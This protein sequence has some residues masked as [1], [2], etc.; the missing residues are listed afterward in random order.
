MS[1][2]LIAAIAV[3]GILLGK[4]FFKKWFNPLTLYCVIMG[5]LVFLYQLK[6]LP[7]PDIIP[8]AW[9]MLAASFI[10]FVLG[11]ITLTTAKNLYSD[12]QLTQTEKFISLKIFDDGGK[13]IKYSILFFSFIGLFVALHR[14][15]I[16]IG[17]FG[18]IQDVIINAAVVYR[19]NVHGEIKEFI[20][21]LPIFIYVGVFLSGIYTAYKGKSSFLSFL[22]ILTIIL[23]ELTY[24]GRGEI[25]FS[26]M[27][28]IFT[29]VLFR[30]LLTSDSTSRFKISKINAIVATIILLAILISASSFIRISR[31]AK[32]NYVGTDKG[33]RQLKDNFLFSPS[34]YLYLSSDVGVFSKY[35][36]LE[37]EKA[38]FGQNT[39]HPLYELLSRIGAVKKPDFFQKGYFIPMWTNTGTFIREVHADF[40]ITG[41]LL[42]PYL[43]GFTI[44]W[45][46]FRFY[47]NKSIYILVLLVYLFLVIGFSFIMMITRLNIWL[48]SLV[49]IM[50]YLPILHKLAG[51]ESSIVSFK[52]Y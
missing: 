17:K 49:F 1:L 21:I 51:R 46:W 11:I 19:L 25:L 35:L 23:K 9:F 37:N 7:Y 16:L 14:W 27:E 43:L 33:L 41:V 28:F 20:P 10:A 31:S 29:F 40:G 24:F 48:F 32:E 5:G 45:L 30:H 4:F 42:I 3:L 44:T 13:A 38:S 50:M 47:R 39:F 12:K 34:V 2:L 8:L 36:E 52:T 22:P 6:L 26:S 18:S 15:F